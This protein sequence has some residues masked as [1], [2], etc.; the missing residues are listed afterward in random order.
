MQKRM[1]TIFLLVVLVLS[2]LLSLYSMGNLQGNARVINYTGV[3]RGATQRLVKEELEGR[4]D[5][6][7]ISKLDGIIEELRTGEGENRLVRLKD[8]EYQEM[9]ALMQERWEEMKQEIRKVREGAD[10]QRLYNLS[11]DFF[12]LA[13][14]SVGTAEQYAE[15]YVRMAQICFAA[16]TL[17]CTA[18]AI[19][20]AVYMR[21]QEQ[22]RREVEM[23]ENA[24]LEKSRKLSRM[25][26]DLQAPM[27]EISELLYVSDMDTYELLFI[28]DAGKRSFH[29]DDIEGKICYRV[30]QGRDSPCPFCTNRFLKSGENYTWEIT[31]P[32]TG[33]HYLLKDRLIEWEGRRARLELAFDTTDAEQEKEKLKYALSS[34]QMVM[35]L[36]LIHI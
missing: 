34:E 31:N 3:V 17:I 13:D 12:E 14:E 24:N 9:V 2:G 33:R 30:L 32:I 16:L 4:R 22:R 5:D 36:S 21:K 20:L 11:E 1:M 29:L 10:S 15:R 18:A 27:N 6:A 7:L 19:L 8:D 26:Q 23:M 25:T 28:N 35:E